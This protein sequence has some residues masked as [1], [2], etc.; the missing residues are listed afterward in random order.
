[1]NSKYKR[2]VGIGSAMIIVGIFSPIIQLLPM[3]ASGK[4]MK[5]AVPDS[6]VVFTFVSLAIALIGCVLLVMGITGNQKA[7]REELLRG[8]QMSPVNGRICPV[9]RIN[10]VQ[11]SQFCP[12]CGKSIE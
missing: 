3:L 5:S 1:M 2:L 7:K 9:C 8:P 12:K 10:L 4:S 11:G 6:L